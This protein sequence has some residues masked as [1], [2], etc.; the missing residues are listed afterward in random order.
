MCVGRTVVAGLT[1]RRATLADL[2]IRGCRLLSRTRI[3]PG[4]R[5][6]VQIPEALEMGD[7]FTVP[8]RVVRVEGDKSDL[9]DTPFSLAVSFGEMA[10]DA[11]EALE[12]II[13]DR[14]HGPATLRPGG[15]GADRPREADGDPAELANLEFAPESAEIEEDTSPVVS[16]AFESV[17]QRGNP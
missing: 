4:K 1:S 9:G 17:A 10:P 2:S 8:G 14:A 7:P 5:I 16:E 11:R 15:A 13:E 3:E 12:L 6:K